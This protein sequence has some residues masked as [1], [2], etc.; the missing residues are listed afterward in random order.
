M[1]LLEWLH[2]VALGDRCG[3]RFLVTL[4]VYRHL[5]AEELWHELMIIR[6]HLLVIVRGLVPFPA[7]SQKVTLVYCS[8][9]W[10]TSLVGRFLWRQVLARCVIPIS[11]QTTKYWLTQWGLACRQAR[12]PQ[13]KNHVSSCDWL[14]PDDWIGI[15]LVIGSFHYTAT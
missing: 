15:H 6:G 11:H 1:R 8:Y 12:E 9:H 2:L 7:E 13:E 4:G 3:C 14:S 10:V 5:A